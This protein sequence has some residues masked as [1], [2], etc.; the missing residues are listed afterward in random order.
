[1]DRSSN[2]AS[3]CDSVQDIM[4]P[5]L[6][7]IGGLKELGSFHTWN[8]CMSDVRTV[9]W[10]NLRWGNPTKRRMKFV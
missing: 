4:S 8:I 7:E 5:T 3:E 9:L 2:S 1:M 10:V 6:E